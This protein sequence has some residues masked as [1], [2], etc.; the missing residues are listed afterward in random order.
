VTIGGS[1][2]TIGALYDNQGRV[3]KLTYPSG[4]AVKHVYT[5][6]GYLSEV[7]DYAGN[8]MYWRADAMTADGQ[9]AAFTHGNNVQTT[10]TFDAALGRLTWIQAGGGNL[11]QNQFYSYDTIGNL[12]NRTDYITG[13][14]EGFGYDA[15]NRLISSHINGSLNKSIQ[16][17][18]IPGSGPGDQ[19]HQQ[20]RH[21][22][23]RLC[24]GASAR[25]GDSHLLRPAQR[26]LHLR[27][28]WQHADRRRAHGEL[29][30]VRHAGVD[31]A[32][33][34]HGQLFLRR[35]A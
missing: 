10:R 9:L 12:T 23:L 33:R 21:R 8:A 16:Y 11:V 13:V 26:H 29:D 1:S 25:R 28:Q 31:R 7:R 32:G 2:Y 22:D 18:A 27:R 35:R 24:R 34:R 20:E 14:G 6:L 30:L 15:L 3:D 4:F 19:H 5:S 17:D